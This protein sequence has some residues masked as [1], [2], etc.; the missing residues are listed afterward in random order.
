MMNLI[1]G[2]GPASLEISISL[3][4]RLSTHKLSQAKDKMWISQLD[5]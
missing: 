2:Q 4:W 1:R 3:A 5:G